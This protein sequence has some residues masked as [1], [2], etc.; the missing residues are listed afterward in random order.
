MLD[1]ITCNTCSNA[2]T[3]I[4]IAEHGIGSRTVGQGLAA[5]IVCMYVCMYVYQSCF[6]NAIKARHKCKG[7]ISP[8]VSTS[9]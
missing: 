4:I 5:S 2:G 9:I 8:F 1:E 3:T 6:W 7:L